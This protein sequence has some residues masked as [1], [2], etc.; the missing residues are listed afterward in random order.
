MI[1]CKIHYT[2]LGGVLCLLSIGPAAGLDAWRGVDLSYVN[3]LEDCGAVYRSQGDPQDPYALFAAAGAN[4]VRLRL[5]HTPGWT[6]Y[7]TLKDV[8]KSA[9]RARQAGMKV[10]LDFHYSDDWAHPGKQM[11]PAAWQGAADTTDLA[12]HLGDYT[13][14]ILGAF[15]AAQLTP[16]FVQVGNEINTNLLWHEEVAEDA[17]VDW[18]RNVRLLNRGIAAVRRAAPTAGVM[19]HIAQPENALRLL[20]GAAAAGIA[21]YDLLGLSYYPKWSSTPFAELEQVV[22]SLRERYETD[23]VVVETAYPWTL[24]G[25]DQA[26]NLLGA[27]SLVAGYPATPT[28]QRRFM[29]DLMSRTRAGGGRG[30]VYWEPAWISSSCRTRWG[31]GSHWENAALFDFSSNLLEGAAF[32][33]PATR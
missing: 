25:Q 24:E 13:E 10:L 5:W 20:D 14:E 4:V 2:L 1:R 6:R 12:R 11:I 16:D 32:L 17:P 23:V 27:D 29:K 21:D 19:I 28:G 30:I 18:T 33:K 9:R 3:E 31:N 15:A 7:S 22:R 8:M 26:N